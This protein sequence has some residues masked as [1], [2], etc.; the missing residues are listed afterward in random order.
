[1]DK[2]FSL[3]S[4]LRW[5]DAVDIVLNSYI[6][7]RFY[8]LLRGTHVFRVL[9]GIA[10]LWFFQRLA[11]FFGLIVTSWAIQ[12][13]TAVAAIIIIVV[14]RNEIRSVLQTKNWKT[15]LWGFPHKEVSTPVDIIVESVSEMAR[16]HTGA[17]IVFPGKDDLAEVVQ[18]GIDWRGLISKEM[19][20]SIFYHDNPVHDGAAVIKGDQVM[21]VGVILPLSH[22]K[23]LP[24][25]YGTRHRAAAGLSEVSD[26]LVV[27]VSEERGDIA[28]AKGSKIRAVN[29]KEELSSLLNEHVGITDAGKS[30]RR[31][32]G[33]ELTGAAMASILLVTGI[34]FSFTRGID[35]LMT[36]EIPIEYVNRDPAKEITNAS[37]NAVRVELSGSGSLI[38]S[39][40]SEQV[41]VRVDLSNAVVGQNTYSIRPENV[42]LPPGVFLK[43]IMPSTVAVNLDVPVKKKVPIQ[44]D[45]AGK[46]PDNLVLAEVKLDPARIE[47][48]D[49]K[50][51][52][53]NISTIYTEKVSLD[54]IKKSGN[55]TV[56]LALNPATLKL[57]SGS[58]DS[59][60]VEFVVKERTESTQSPPPP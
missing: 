60:A 54:N 18:N 59:V 4:S 44:V 53:E 29:G 9:I 11:V 43:N 25:Y 15:I 27:V 57:V 22:Q 37:I 21:Q 32:K 6:L 19:I 31:K 14:F 2:F 40:S 49:A 34:W 5:Q 42:I 50:Q 1:M 47:V 56:R 28:V 23:D 36:L 8:V 7:F 30:Y 39:I 48:I 10:F 12:G 24:S 3:F 35:T 16:A 58:K 26:A 51:V 41:K 20:K 38:K 45:W 13:I 52:L 17:L 55:M 46:L 33:F